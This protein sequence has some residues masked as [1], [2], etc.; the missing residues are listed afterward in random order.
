MYEASI[1]SGKEAEAVNTPCFDLQARRRVGCL[2]R[3]KLDL[4]AF[5]FLLVSL[6][7]LDLLRHACLPPKLPNRGHS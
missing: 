2:S 3:T 7:L 4:R 6:V 1:R 5:A